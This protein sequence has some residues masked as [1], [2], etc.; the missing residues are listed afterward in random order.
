[1]RISA[2]PVCILSI[3]ARQIQLNFARWLTQAGNTWSFSIHSLRH[4][5][6]TRL[7]RKTGGLYLVQRALGHR[8]PATTEGCAKGSD[9]ALREAV[10]A[11]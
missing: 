11:A 2:R 8:Q 5:F 3:G 10:S 4:G 9:D 7:Y 1:M 6:A